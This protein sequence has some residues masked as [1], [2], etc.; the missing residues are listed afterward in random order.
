MYRKDEEEEGSKLRKKDYF[1]SFAP[2][3]NQPSKISIELPASAILLARE[4]LE[5][6]NPLIP[7]IRSNHSFCTRW[8]SLKKPADSSGN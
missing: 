1:L 6:R 7:I 5:C 2:L 8:I 4:R 3:L